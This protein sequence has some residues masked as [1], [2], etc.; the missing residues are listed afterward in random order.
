MRFVASI[1]ALAV[2]LFVA[3]A[4]WKRDTATNLLVLREYPFLDFFFPQ[5]GFR[6]ALFVAISVSDPELMW[7][8]HFFSRVCRCTGTARIQVLL[9]SPCQIQRKRFYCRWVHERATRH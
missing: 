8:D 5:A 2:P 3:A 6:S 1:I 4:P 7:P 9:R